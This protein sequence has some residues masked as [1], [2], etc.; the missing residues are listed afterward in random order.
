MEYFVPQPV[1]RVRPARVG[2][3]GKA[4]AWTSGLINAFIG[5]TIAPG[6]R[7][8]DFPIHL[9]IGR[10]RRRPAARER[11]LARLRWALMGNTKQ[12]IATIFGPPITAVAAA[13]II[14][15]TE[16]I[17]QADT[18]YYPLDSRRH[19]AI[20]IEFRRNAVSRVEFLGMAA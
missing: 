10:R 8:S 16:P 13:P 17:Y 14:G 20:A 7:A 11:S 18:W 2:A 15:C 4:W 12:S 3:L 6:R 5:S 9:S 19:M 1:P